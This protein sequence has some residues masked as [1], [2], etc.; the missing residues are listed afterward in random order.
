VDVR[1]QAQ[2]SQMHTLEIEHP[3]QWQHPRASPTIP[4]TKPS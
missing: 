2:R 4:S 1:K 3:R